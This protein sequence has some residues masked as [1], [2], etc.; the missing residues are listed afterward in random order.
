MSISPFQQRLR[1]CA[2]LAFPA[3][4]QTGYVSGADTLQDPHFLSDMVPAG[5]WAAR[6]EWRY[7]VSDD[8]Y[9]ERGER[10]PLAADLNGVD[11]NGAVV[12]L[13]AALGP[14]ASLG[15]TD[16]T[17]KISG[18][19]QRLTVGYGVSDDLTVGF[20]LPYGTTHSHVDFAMLGGNLAANPLFNPTQPISPANSPLVPVGMLGTTTPVGTAGVQDLLSNPI[21]GYEYDPVGS[22][23]VSGILDPSV[24]LRWRF[25]R[26]E[27]YS[28]ILTPALR[29][30]MT[31][32]NDPDNLFDA[33]LEDGST[34]VEMAV[35][36]LRRLNGRFDTRINVKYTWQTPDQYTARALAIGE[37]LVPISRTEKLKRDLGDIAEST[38]ELGYRIGAWRASAAVELSYQGAT[39][40][41]SPRGQTVSGL[42]HN[43]DRF[44]NNA[45]LGLAWSGV[46]AWRENRLPLPLFV[47]L[48]YRGTYRGE[49]VVNSDN[50]YLTVTGIF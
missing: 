16:L 46:N 12:P 49:N 1:A 2:L 29:I 27:R 33:R 9:D 48:A 22:V 47:S 19:R 39:D 50:L 34:D 44:A 38:L 21:Y 11:L 41:S 26:G 8:R 3:M 32:R 4:L 15:S 7:G 17:W 6:A 13:L 23:T 31:E 43:T 10:V 24:G 36:Y 25:L 37:S 5:H 28:L 30:G 18:V 35:D 14:G 40:Y 20:I 45:Y 42:E